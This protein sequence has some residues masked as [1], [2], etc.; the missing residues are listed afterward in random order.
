MKFFAK[1]FIGT[2]LLLVLL[3]GIDQLMLRV[4]LEQPYLAPL[5]KFYVDF[6]SRLFQMGE[7]SHP[8]QAPVPSAKTAPRPKVETIPAQDS[9]LLD[10]VLEQALDAA[11]T[12]NQ[13]GGDVPEYLYV[14]PDGVLHFAASLDEI[15]PALRGTAQKLKP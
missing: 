8:Y 14:D 10:K 13:A 5:Q 6:R 2:I 7:A 4:P 9:P 11:E 3:V 15:P 1:Y 12:A